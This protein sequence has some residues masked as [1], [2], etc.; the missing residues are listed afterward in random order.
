MAFAEAGSF[1]CDIAVVEGEI[2]VAELLKEL[3][4]DFHPGLRVGQAPRAVIPRADRRPRSELVGQPVAEGVPVNHREPQV[5]AH[6]LAADHLLG[7]V[8]LELQRVFDRGRRTGSWA[9]SERIRAWLENLAGV[10]VTELLL[11]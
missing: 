6:R 3:E 9:R 11:S 2:G 4:G 10:R 1:G 7:V 5:L 8:V